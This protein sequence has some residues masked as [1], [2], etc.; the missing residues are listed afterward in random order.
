MRNLC[1]LFQRSKQLT[2]LL[3]GHKADTFVCCL[4]IDSAMV[5]IVQVRKAVVLERQ[6]VVLDTDLDMDLQ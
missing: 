6:T 4:D 3:Q 2:V 5:D 1:K